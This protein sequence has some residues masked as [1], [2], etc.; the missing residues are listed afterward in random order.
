MMAKASTA[1]R[2]LVTLHYIK[3]NNV[4]ILFSNGNAGEFH[5]WLTDGYGP[6]VRIGIRW[7]QKVPKYDLG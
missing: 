2:G 7:D 4:L 5:I 6:T 1:T 3:W